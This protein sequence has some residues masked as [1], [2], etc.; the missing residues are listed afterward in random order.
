[1]C[2]CN[3]STRAGGLVFDGRGDLPDWSGRVDLYGRE[4]TCMVSQPIGPRKGGVQ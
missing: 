2:I 1:M 4:T 3:Q